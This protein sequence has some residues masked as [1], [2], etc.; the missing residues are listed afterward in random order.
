MVA[1]D[2]VKRVR[3]LAARADVNDID[4]W[5]RRVVKDL[6]A[7]L[8][9]AWRAI[10]ALTGNYLEDHATAEGRAV[11][12]T[13]A[14]WSTEQVLTSLR[15]TGP[16][17]FKS[18]IDDGHTPQHAKAIMASRLSGAAEK[19]V[20]RGDRDTV[21]A[22]VEASD[23]IIGWRRVSD[24]D[25]CAWCAMLVSR[26]AVYET[27]FSATRVV[28]QRG[29]TRGNQPIGA[30]YHDHCHCSAEPLYEHEQEPP[31]VQALY[32]AW[33]KVTA[34]KS[35]ADAMR[36]WRSDW[37]AMRHD[38]ASQQ[39]KLEPTSEPEPSRDDQQLQ[40]RARN[41][42]AAIDAQRGRAEMLAELEEIAVI[43]QTDGDELARMARRAADR[44]GVAD[45]PELAALLR[46]AVDGDPAMIEATLEA[47]A[48]RLGLTRIGGDL[49]SEQ[50]VKFDKARHVLPPGERATPF[51]EI[52]RPGYVAVVDGEQRVI[53]PARVVPTDKRPVPKANAPAALTEAASRFHRNL[54]G[55]EDLAAI[56]ADVDDSAE[57]RKLSGGMSAAVELVKLGDGRVIIHKRAHD[58]GDPEMLAEIQT[59]AEAEL[60][61]PLLARALDVPVARVYR[62]EPDAVWVEFIDGSLDAA[63]ALKGS[64]DWIRLGLL[65]MLTANL[66]RNEG[67]LMAHNGRLVGYDHG[68]NWGQHLIEEPNPIPGRHGEPSQMYSGSESLR[69]NP[70]AAEDIDVIR[71]RME[72][73]RPDFAHVG[74]EFWLDYSLRILEQLRPHAKGTRRFYA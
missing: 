12:P 41:R 5:F 15:V 62:N 16:V 57:R 22:T 38:L 50:I 34:G 52:A 48:E 71:E 10:R 17:A 67:N 68:F 1:N 58:W 6:V 73:L 66:D 27:R 51:V 61:T 21:M 11:V 3:Q 59:Q 23:E 30:S 69:A 42:Q 55:I 53:V 36:A 72:A 46:R 9:A 70:L 28:G 31:E 24:G 18:A 65:D 37:D 47:V 20:L 74:R 13:L 4:G 29:A 40:Q 19:T 39:R 54:D 14:K 44:F 32:N 35:G 7:L 45:D 2:V 60:L 25:P 26:G 33:L 56:V 49:E 63:D 43:N 8:A 64:D